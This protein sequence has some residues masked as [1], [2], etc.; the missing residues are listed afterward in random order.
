MSRCRL[1]TSNDR[2]ALL[3]SVAADLWESRRRGTLDDY[4]WTE[5]PPYW[6]TIYLELAATAIESLEHHHDG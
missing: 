4:P 5:C 6:R 1:C 3:D 2:D